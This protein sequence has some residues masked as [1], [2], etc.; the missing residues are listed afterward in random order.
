MSVG[1]ATAPLAGLAVGNV[2]V[3]ED[4]VAHLAAVGRPV[5]LPGLC[6]AV[7]FDALD[8]SGYSG[9]AANDI[10]SDAVVVAHGYPEG[11]DRLRPQPAVPLGAIVSIE[12]GQLLA[13]GE[14]V[15]KEGAHPALDAGWVPRWLAGAPALP[16]GD[17]VPPVDYQPPAGTRVVRERLV[18]DFA[19]FGD[20]I[21]PEP[22]KLARLR[23]KGRCLDGYGHL[24]IDASYTGGDDEADDVA[25]WAG[26]T[27]RR[28]PSALEATGIGSAAE[29]LAAATNLA[30]ALD[31]DGNVRSFGSHYIHAGA[32]ERLVAEDGRGGRL[33]HVARGLAHVAGGQH[34]GWGSMSAR[35]ADELGEDA[36]AG[37]AW[38]TKVVTASLLALDILGEEAPTGDWNGIH[39]RIDDTWQGGGLWRTERLGA[40]GP[41]AAE[42]AVAL[43]L[44]WAEHTGGIARRP[45]LRGDMPVDVPDW[46]RSDGDEDGAEEGDADWELVGSEVTW[47]VHVTGA[48]IDTA[49]LRVPTQISELVRNALHAK[50]QDRLVVAFSHAGEAEQRF[51]IEPGGDGHLDMDWPLGLWPGTT[52]R[53]SWSLGG[54]VI[55]ASTALLVEPEIVAGITYTHAYNLRVALAAAGVRDDAARPVTLRQLVRAAVAR[56]GDISE[57]G[58]W[59]LEVDIVVARCFGPGGE[60]A[61]AFHA[62]VLRRA[63]L[64]AVRSLVTAGLAALDGDVI[65]VEPR[66]HRAGRQADAALLARYA[67]AIAEQVRRQKALHWVPATVVNLPVG[68]QRSEEKDRSWFEVAGTENLPAGP[69]APNQTWRR[70]HPRGGTLPADV[71][72]RLE[73][74]RQALKSLPGAES[75]LARLDADPDDLV[76]DRD[77]VTGA[78]PCRKTE[79]P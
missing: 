57:D 73:R 37:T 40:E 25:F 26:W 43:G 14:V 54:T 58:R 33:H 59:A 4:V 30:D 52:V 8:R 71:T 27:A 64:G 44:G 3:V 41:I 65:F 50:G 79:D 36:V 7:A 24:V 74:V 28:H 34:A 9:E 62:H 70:G 1:V 48:D 20:G 39:L 38:P 72:E 49:R 6:N 2:A 12:A 42:P 32:Y 35:L 10:F 47:L 5:S 53:C 55:T 68:W 63:V 31:A 19:C 66:S 29:L 56:H 15:W 11:R 76:L 45:S 75:A 69:L 23:Y 67:D 13:Y 78:K 21:A 18:V 77:A 61:P 51:W 46:Y 17:D 16:D 60:L 22:A